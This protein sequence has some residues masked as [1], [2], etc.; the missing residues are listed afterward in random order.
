MK[1]LHVLIVVDVLLVVLGA[2]LLLTGLLLEFVLPAHSRQAT[3]WSMTRHEWGDVHFWIAAAMAGLA[4]LH[5]ALHWQWVCMQAMR[6]V[7]L[8]KSQ[9]HAG[10]RRI[11]GVVTALLLA[12]LIG[13]F[14]WAAATV[15]IP[16]GAGGGEA[17]PGLGRGGEPRHQHRNR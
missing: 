13:A 7:G 14:L 6:V 4:L 11:A 8:S 3:V 9:P 10:A 17:G 1:K 12:A 15:K 2:G 16:S 5:V